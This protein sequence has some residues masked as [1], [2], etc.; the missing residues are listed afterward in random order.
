MPDRHST[1]AP[2]PALET[3]SRLVRAIANAHHA[4]IEVGSGADGKGTVIRVTF[5]A[6]ERAA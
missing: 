6:P 1:T 4:Q 5:A 3:T 2:D